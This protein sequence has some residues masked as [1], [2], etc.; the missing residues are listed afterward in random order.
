MTISLDLIKIG[1]DDKVFSR[2]KE[3]YK[4]NPYNKLSFS[5]NSKQLTISAQ[6]KEYETLIT[7]SLDT[8]N[9]VK[10]V[11]TCPYYEN[12]NKTCK[13]IVTLAFQANQKLQN[14]IKNIDLL[15]GEGKLD[16]I[17]NNIINLNSQ[18][19]V[20]DSIS[21]EQSVS[22][23]TRKIKNLLEQDKEL[24]NIYVK[25]EISAFSP[26]RSGHIYFT[27]KDDFALLSCVMFKTSASNLDFKPKTGD[28]VV[29]KGSIIIYEPRGTYQFLA[30]EM[31]KE[32][33]GDLFQK[34]I[35]LKNKLQDQGLFNEQNKKLIPTFPKI[36]G[37]VSSPTGAVIKDI[38]N[39]IDRRFPKVKIVLYQASVQGDGSEKT[40]IAGIEY[41]EERG[42][43]DTLIV[44]RGGGSL[45]DLWCFN[46]ETLAR[47]IFSCKI[48]TISA[49]G[50]ETDFTIC[51]FVSDIRAPT[52]TAAAELSTPN[53]FDLN[54]SLN[55]QNKRMI[56][57]L[58]HNLENKKIHLMRIESEIYTG[59]EHNISNKRNVLDTFK[60][61]LK[62]L[63][64]NS[65][66][67]RGFSLTLDKDGKCIKDVNALK[68]GERITTLLNNGKVTSIVTTINNNKI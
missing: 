57:S 63:S 35:E 54:Y 3:Y 27:I 21:N 13:H 39:T 43:I 67:S 25:G 19:K 26:N 8:G 24:N 60:G 17:Q 18:V 45:E 31:K 41:F 46:D 29:L 10:N 44:A 40:I 49:I 20:N 55:I 9:I 28:Q 68:K 1:T 36:I 30:K 33:Q 52:P 2:G 64:I 42:D 47:K 58:T 22:E 65:T 23:L 15:E 11:C 12:N 6:I 16:E 38:I 51:D 34:F 4:E 48:P 59:F 7:Y 56:H 66:L 53:L 61:K 5:L 50:H 14:T 62:L 32:G 37:V